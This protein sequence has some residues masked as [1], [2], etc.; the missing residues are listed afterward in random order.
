MIDGIFP[1]PIGRYIFERHFSYDEIN[2][3]NSLK[4]NTNFGNSISVDKFVL[5]LPEFK[6]I[7][8][9]LEGCLT[10][11]FQTVY[12]P[13]N[14]TNIY[15][16]QSWI[17]WSTKGQ[18]HHQHAHPNSFISG[19]LYIQAN[20]DT[21]KIVFHKNNYRQLE[22][23]P[24]DRHILNSDTWYYSVGTGDIMFFSSDLVHSVP[25]IDT[26]QTRISLSFNSFIEGELG[27]PEGPTKLILKK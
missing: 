27:V 11:F 20:K 3:I 2:F 5:D 7:R 6:E 4:K 21:D 9:S 24:K 25:E 12:N 1:V 10:D 15:I 18:Y 8:N 23:I 16:T 26:D 17:N 22:I 19:V 13:K 14:K